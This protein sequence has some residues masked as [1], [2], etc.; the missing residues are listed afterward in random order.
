MKGKN[1][2]VGTAV[3]MLFWLVTLS[4]AG[5]TSVNVHPT[6]QEVAP[7]AAFQV[8]V[9]VTDVTNM[10]ADGT[11]LHFEPSAMQATG[12]AAGV[13]D[14]FPIEKIDNVNGTVTFAYARATGGYTGSGPLATIDFTAGMTEGLFDLGLTDVELLRPDGSLIPTDVNNGTVNITAPVGPLLCTDPDP[15][16][17]DFGD[18]P[19][20]QT[21]TWSFDITNC[22]A[23]TLIWAVVDDQPWITESPTSIGTTTTETDT[24]TVTTDTTGLTPDTTYFGTITVASNGGIKVGII[25]MNV[26]AGP[27]AAVPVLSGT[28]MIVLIGLLTAVFAISVS[29]MRKRRK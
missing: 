10:A 13:I 7:G 27:P 28:G 19:E 22:G 6:D 20:G 16:S 25:R 11:I 23:G 21:R 4:I 1:I 29:V 14:T 26:I 9:N 2:A 8:E 17:H 15:P 24:V 3:L 18:V 12:I 5:A